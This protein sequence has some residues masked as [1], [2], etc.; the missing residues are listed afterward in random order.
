[1]TSNSTKAS[2]V[3][4]GDLAR[5]KRLEVYEHETGSIQTRQVEDLKSSGEP[6]SES[7]LAKP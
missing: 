6:S 5:E 1:M 3:T 7:Y 4:L 2:H